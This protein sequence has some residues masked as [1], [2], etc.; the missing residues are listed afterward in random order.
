MHVLLPKAN[1]NHHP[2]H[3]HF[4]VVAFNTAHLRRGSKGLDPAHAHVRLDE[5]TLQLGSGTPDL[6]VCSGVANL[7]ALVSGDLDDDLFGS[8]SAQRLA[9]RVTI[10]AGAM[11]AVERGACWVW[12]AGVLATS[13][14]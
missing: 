10:G 9:G 8:D 6:R 4:A 1:L 14:S 2:E 5:H 13:I 11:S 12:E 3:N 7:K